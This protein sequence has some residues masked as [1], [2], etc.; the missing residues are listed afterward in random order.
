MSVKISKALSYLVLPLIFLN[1]SYCHAE[2]LE[3]L[4]NSDKPI[5]LPINKQIEKKEYVKEQEKFDKTNPNSVRSYSNLNT[6][7]SKKSDNTA[8]YFD[9][10][11]SLKM[12]FNNISPLANKQTEKEECMES[13]RGFDKTNIMPDLFESYSNLDIEINKRMDDIAKCFG[14]NAQF[15]IYVDSVVFQFNFKF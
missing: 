8:K 11:T 1:P 12:Y 9:K 10:N 4:V 5:I 15:G 14:K 6:E 13:W 2:N 7:L 3:K